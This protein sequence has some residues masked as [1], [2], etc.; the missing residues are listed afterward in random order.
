MA[1][2]KRALFS[3]ATP[4]AIVLIVCISFAFRHRLTALVYGDIVL[5]YEQDLQIPWDVDEVEAELRIWNGG[6]GDLEIIGLSSPCPSC[7]KADQIPTT[8]H[9]LQ[10][11]VIRIHLPVSHLPRGEKLPF[12]F[13]LLCDRRVVNA[14]FAYTLYRNP[15]PT[16]DRTPTLAQPRESKPSVVSQ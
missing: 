11:S 2:S 3:A 5:D 1:L 7:I 14:E 6:L 8:I 15:A 13:R 9:A 4:V 12:S 16:D 10:S